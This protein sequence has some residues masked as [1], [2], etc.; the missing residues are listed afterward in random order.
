MLRKIVNMLM[1]SADDHG[2]A[3]ATPFEHLLERARQSFAARLSAANGDLVDALAMAVMQE[4]LPK[5][6]SVSTQAS[7]A[8]FFVLVENDKLPIGEQ[9]E[10]GEID[11]LKALLIEY[12]V[13]SEAVRARANEVLALIERKFSQGAF[14][15]ARILLQ[16]FET[17]TETR[18]NN[19]RNLFYEDMI[20]R[21]GVRRRHELGNTER[22]RIAQQLAKLDIQAE[23]GVRQALRHLSEE[24]YT[25]FCLL[26]RNPAQRSIW[27][28]TL[29][30]F[31]EE[32]RERVLHYV[33]PLRWRTPP[34][35]PQSGLLDLSRQLINTETAR[36][37]IQH[38]LKMCYFLLLA[39]GDTGYEEFIY[40]FL[41]FSRSKLGVEAKRALPLLHRRSVLDEKG[42][43]E[44]LDEVY[45]QRFVDAVDACLDFGDEQLIAAWNALITKL[46]RVDFNQIPPGHYD[47]VAF[48]LDELLGFEA[49]DLVF[50]F[51]LYRLS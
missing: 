30:S 51:R 34:Q 17:D 41:Q 1:G 6:E 2:D 23:G 3:A 40:S 42:L 44:T 45:D 38:L 48:L 26:C 19:E 35:F 21:L 46:Q 28:K 47:L 31:D 50:P 37:H 36:Q 33:P 11:L 14:T 13:G 49:P 43:Q 22:E 16:I 5:G 9:L 25:H 29:A 15:Q 32:H 18:L 10:S 4:S 39:S 20:M 27:D 24:H 7:R 12:F 8:F